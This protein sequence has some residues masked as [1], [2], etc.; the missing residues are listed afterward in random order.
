MFPQ[1]KLVF[2]FSLPRSGSTLLQRSLAA[3]SGFTSAP[4]TWVL[5]K[6]LGAISGISEYSEYGSRWANRGVSEFF[7]DERLGSTAA[8]EALTT[9][10]L[11]MLGEVCE[12]KPNTYFIEKTPRNS[13]VVQQ[14]IELFPDSKF[15]FL[16]RHPAAVIHSMNDSWSKGHWHF[17]SDVDLELGLPRLMEARASLGAQALSVNYECLVDDYQRTMRTVLDFLGESSSEVVDPVVALG[18]GSATMGDKSGIEKY[19]SA[20]VKDESWTSGYQNSFRRFCLRS[21]L[22]RIGLQ[23]WADIGYS[24]QDLEK[25][26]KSRRVIDRYLV[27]DLLRQIYANLV[28]K[29]GLEMVARRIFSGRAGRRYGIY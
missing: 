7:A 21:Y 10:Y 29:T 8:R 4:E 28:F 27:T 25:P 14:I 6:L 19:G 12:G 24:E 17:R 22:R 13:L 18:P 15:I 2:I 5:V 11:S 3:Q 20:V 9:A 23:Q 1:N 16:W 26:F